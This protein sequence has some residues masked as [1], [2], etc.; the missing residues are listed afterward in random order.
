MDVDEVGCIYDYGIEVKN[1]WL[2]CENCN[3]KFILI[4]LKWLGVK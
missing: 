1:M 2:S 3:D 4:C